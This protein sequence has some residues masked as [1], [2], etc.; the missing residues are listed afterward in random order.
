[1]TKYKAGDKV[2]IALDDVASK[3]LNNGET[4]MFDEC[5]IIEHTAAPEPMIVFVN[6]YEEDGKLVWGG[7]TWEG[8][9]H[10]GEV[11]KQIKITYH[12]GEVKA[13]VI[14]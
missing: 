6:I 13:E 1:M 14:E 10:V 7:S 5:E 8:P 3:Q 11:E 9:Q 12:N 4:A 2:T